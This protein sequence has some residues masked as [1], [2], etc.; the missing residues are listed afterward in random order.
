VNL[1]FERAN[2]GLTR[3]VH[4]GIIASVKQ[5]SPPAFPKYQLLVFRKGTRM[6]KG[7][8]TTREDAELAGK[9]YV[10]GYEHVSF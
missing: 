7:E 5:P 6:F 1:Q 3:L 4:R 2:Y 9:A 8:F 10:M